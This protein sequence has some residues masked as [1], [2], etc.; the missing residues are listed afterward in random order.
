MTRQ[1]H[2]HMTL[3]LIIFLGAALMGTVNMPYTFGAV[4]I[5]YFGPMLG[6]VILV[7]AALGVLGVNVWVGGPLDEELDT[8]SGQTPSV[9]DTAKIQ[10]IYMLLG[11]AAFIIA[12][13]DGF[14]A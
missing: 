7:I 4:P 6:A 12:S 14:F 2:R 9:S 5:R 11:P 3:A 13:M 8:T 10:T 1:Q